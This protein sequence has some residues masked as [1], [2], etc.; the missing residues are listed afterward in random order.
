VQ[1][2]RPAHGR[3]SH[4]RCPLRH[5]NTLFPP[6]QSL[7][8]VRRHGT[9]SR[10]SFR[11]PS[12]PR[13][14]QGTNPITQRSANQNTNGVVNAPRPSQPAPALSGETI[15]PMRHLNDRMMYLLAN[16][17]VGFTRAEIVPKATSNVPCPGAAGSH[18]AEE[19]RE[20]HRRALGHQSRSNRDALRL[21]D[22][23]EGPSSK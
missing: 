14:W 3:P 7:V 12:Q 19:R 13:A 4:H 6:S 10:P 22:G 8:P 20:V 23:Q 18:Y 9:N 21:Q 5:C 16:L 11:K 2:S 17:S 1:R 15:T